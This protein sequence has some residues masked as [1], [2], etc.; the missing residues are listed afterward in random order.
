MCISFTVLPP[1]SFSR[2]CSQARGVVGIWPAGTVD[3][4]DIAV[5]SDE[6]RSTQ[7]GKFCTLR[8]QVLAAV[9]ARC[10]VVAVVAPCTRAWLQAE[11]ETDDPYYAL[12]DFIAPADG[13]VR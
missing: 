4:D 3:S 7:L 12:A 2:L 10:L 13:G 5:F 9:C 8:Q 11:H 6:S 1:F